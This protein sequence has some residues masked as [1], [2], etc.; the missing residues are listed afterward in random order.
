M[1]LHYFSASEDGQF[2][3]SASGM[4]SKLFEDALYILGFYT[5]VLGICPLILKEQI[6]LVQKNY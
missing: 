5:L 4:A 3:D 6:K 1:A 2:I